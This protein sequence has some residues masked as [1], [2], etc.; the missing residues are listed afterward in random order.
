MQ[1]TAVL[2]AERRMK[3]A[4]VLVVGMVVLIVLVALAELVRMAANRLFGLLGGSRRARRRGRGRSSSD[5]WVDVRE[6][7]RD[8]EVLQSRPDIGMSWTS[9]ERRGR[10]GR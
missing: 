10:R 6:A 5:V 1:S 2:V 9:W 3:V 7:R 8:A 4:L